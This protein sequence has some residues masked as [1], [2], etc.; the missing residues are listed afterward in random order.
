MQKIAP[1]KKQVKSKPDDSITQRIFEV[2]ISIQFLTNILSNKVPVLV[3]IAAL[4]TEKILSGSLM[5]FRRRLT[6]TIRAE[7]KLFLLGVILHW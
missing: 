7:M 1:D 5:E 3:N 2:F 6:A 4:F